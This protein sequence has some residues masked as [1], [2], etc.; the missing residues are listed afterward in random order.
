MIEMDICKLV[1]LMFQQS[2]EAEASGKEE[3]GDGAMSVELPEEGSGEK[4]VD[5]GKKAEEV[6]EN[7]DN[8]VLSGDITI[9]S[10]RDH[11]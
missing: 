8:S 5:G 9:D 4:A 6:R 11:M 7:G 3:K 2:E 1:L 10:I